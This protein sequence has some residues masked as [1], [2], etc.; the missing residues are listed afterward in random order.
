MH[1]MKE[2]FV[3][4]NLEPWYPYLRFWNTLL[5]TI[6]RVLVLRTLRTQIIFNSAMYPGYDGAHLGP[7]SW[8]VK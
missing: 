7:S 6:I 8:S 2:H 1:L 5:G 3:D 4:P